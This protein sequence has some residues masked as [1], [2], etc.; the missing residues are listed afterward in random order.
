MA[1]GV[2]KGSILR[3]QLL[4]GTPPVG[5]GDSVCR[6]RVCG[7]LVFG[8]PRPLPPPASSGTGPV[9]WDVVALPEPDTKVL[10]LAPEKPDHPF[11]RAYPGCW[12]GHGS[13]TPVP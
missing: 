3:W 2:G 6:F 13:P 10:T 4:Y 5:S 12:R 11:S 1:E 7:S 9:L 8:E